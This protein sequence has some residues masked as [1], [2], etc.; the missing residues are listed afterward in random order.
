MDLVKAL[1]S[2]GITII[3]IEHKLDVV[4][5]V[6]DRIVVLDHGVKIAEGKPSLV[7]NDEKVIEA[8]LGRRRRAA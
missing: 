8:Y 4:M 3:L 2:L 6:S 7:R 5:D 1:R